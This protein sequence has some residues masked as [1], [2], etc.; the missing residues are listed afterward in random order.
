MSIKDSILSHSNQFKHYKEEAGKLKKENKKLKKENK[1]IKE[2]ISDLNKYE[3]GI[4]VIIPT[5]KGE[6]HI[7]TLLESLVKQTVASE[8]YELIFIFNGELDSTIDIL[9]EFVK[10][11]PKMNVTSTF[12]PE[13]GASNARNIGIELA[14]KE[15]I[16][17]VDDDD[18]ISPNYLEKLI[19]HSKPKRITMANFLNYDVDTRKA[20]STIPPSEKEYGIIKNAPVKFMSQAAVTVAKTI[21]TC[22]AKRVKFNTDLK[23]G[24]DVSFYA[25][26]YA[27]SDFEFYFIN[28]EEEVNYYRIQR[29]ISV[30]KQEMTYQFNVLD[31]L[32][33][34]DDLDKNYR[35]AEN[36]KIRK[37]IEMCFKGQTGFIQRYLQMHPEDEDKVLKEIEKHDF[38]YFPYF[39]LENEK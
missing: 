25:S 26:L 15:Y 32:K 28:K 11:N 22:A 36:K 2:E 8:F 12:T 16:T 7:Q 23:S 30:S 21:P 24:E 14:R 34:M 10:N 6:N 5:Y 20:E 9:S 38:K 37:Y 13:S 31:R 35:I 18:F 39:L 29:K 4:S 17:F 1:I 19:E 27:K 33:V 3:T